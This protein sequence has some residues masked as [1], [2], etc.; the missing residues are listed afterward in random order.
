MTH[1]AGAT[2]SQ[3]R[4]PCAGLRPAWRH[5]SSVFKKSSQSLK[6]YL[7]LA[8]LSNNSLTLRVIEWLTPLGQ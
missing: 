1:P 6:K 5:F 3:G 2:S 4:W 7:I 8:A